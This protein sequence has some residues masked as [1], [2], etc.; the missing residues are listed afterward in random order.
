[1]AKIRNGFVS[2][3]S[4]SSFVLNRAMLTPLQERLIENYQDIARI[5]YKGTDEENYIDDDY[6]KVTFETDIIK[7]YTCMDNFDMQDF[8]MQIEVPA[9]AFKE[10]I[11]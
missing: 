7:F 1:M 2:N 6:W 3:S 8:L 10:L 5:I 9:K 11:G 4:S